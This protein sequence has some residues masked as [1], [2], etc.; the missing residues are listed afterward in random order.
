MNAAE[1]SQEIKSLIQEGESFTFE[2]FSI[3]KIRDL[4]VELSPIWVS[5]QNRSLQLITQYFSENTNLQLLIKSGIEINLIGAKKSRFKESRLYIIKA[6]KDA[7][8]TINLERN[9]NPIKVLP[10]LRAK[11]QDLKRKLF[12]KIFISYPPK[13]DELAQR[14]VAVFE[15]ALNIRSGDIRCASVPGYE[16]P[17]GIKIASQLRAE[18][19]QAEIAIGMITPERNYSNVL[20]ELGAAWGFQ[21]PIFLLLTRGATIENLPIPLQELNS[22]ILSDIQRCYELIDQ[23]VSKTTLERKENAR[24]RVTRAIQKLVEISSETHNAESQEK[25]NRPSPDLDIYQNAA[26]TEI[27]KLLVGR[28]TCTIHIDNKNTMTEQPKY[29]LSNAQFAGGFAETVQGNQEGGSIHNYA[30]EQKQNLAEAAAEIR[31]IL[32]ELEQSY[33]TNT[34]AEKMTVAAKAIERIERDPTFK[35]RVTNAVKEGG[36][37]AFERAIDNP[38]GA[39]VAGA[40]EGWQDAEAEQT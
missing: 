9:K 33:P 18:L 31:G 15:S 10:A 17:I 35:Q 7:Q 24:V 22:M 32:E 29:D 25:D 19:E 28:P 6:L 14:L 23:L 40:V 20:F 4:P 36:L 8:K 27:T 2:N 3:K 16:F 1:V 11:N 5:W 39:F 26:M 30:P 12:P 37:K 34:T 38:F 13:R 21:K